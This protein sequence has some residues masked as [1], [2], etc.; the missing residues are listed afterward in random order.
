SGARITMHH[1]IQ[2][3]NSQT[4]G[5]VLEC[6][7]IGERWEAPG[8]LGKD[9]LVLYHVVILSGDEVNPTTVHVLINALDGTVF[10]TSKEERRIG[11]GSWEASGR[12]AIQD[13]MLNG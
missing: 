4:P 5:K 7:L 13:G 6:S 11:L 3:A 9:S 8:R 12:R 1:A 2:I 10:K